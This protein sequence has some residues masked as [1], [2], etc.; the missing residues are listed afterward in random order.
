MNK[1]GKKINYVYKAPKQTQTEQQ[2]KIKQNKTKKRNGKGYNAPE[3]TQL[4]MSKKFP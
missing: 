2:H 4:T 1:K 3:K